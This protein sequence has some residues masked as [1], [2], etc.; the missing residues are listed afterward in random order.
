MATRR[1]KKSVRKQARMIPSWCFD[2]DV[3][4]TLK[5]EVE[6]GLARHAVDNGMSPNNAKFQ[7]LELPDILPSLML[8]HVRWRAV[9][10]TMI[11]PAS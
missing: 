3:P 8:V 1:K 4:V 2:R 6:D 5:R 9:H 10:A 7:K 11:D